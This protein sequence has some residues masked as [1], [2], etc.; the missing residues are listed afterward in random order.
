LLSAERMASLRAA[1]RSP[2][3][4]WPAPNSMREVEPGTHFRL[5]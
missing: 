3:A 5:L 4:A 2:G 1:N